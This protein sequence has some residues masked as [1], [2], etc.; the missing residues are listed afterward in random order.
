[1][2]IKII[3][4][5]IDNLRLGEYILQIVYLQKAVIFCFFF[6]FIFFNP[7]NYENWVCHS[8]AIVCQLQKSGSIR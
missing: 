7:G 3:V 2:N 6:L 5:V 4:N 1:M 8:Y